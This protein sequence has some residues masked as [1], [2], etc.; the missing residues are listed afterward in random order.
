MKVGFENKKYKAKHTYKD[1]Y[2][3]RKDSFAKLLKYSDN[4]EIKNDSSF[5]GM[6]DMVTENKDAEFIKMSDEDKQELINRINNYSS[7]RISY[8]TDKQVIEVW[9]NAL[10]TFT[11]KNPE[12]KEFN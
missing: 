11:L 2:S 10:G 12:L 5:N 9:S 6:V 7:Y 8:I 1:S 4:W 3:I